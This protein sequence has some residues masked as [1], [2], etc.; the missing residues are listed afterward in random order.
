MPSGSVARTI[1]PAIF[2]CSTSKIGFAARLRLASL[3][4]AS[5]TATS[6]T[7]EEHH[8]ES[9]EHQ[10]NADIH[11]QPFPKSISEEREIDAD[12]DDYHRHHEKYDDYLS[13]HFRSALI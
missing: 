9:C 13:A 4:F 5:R 8:V 1:A 12:Y 10:D 7:P 3:A 6:W 11:N 2:H